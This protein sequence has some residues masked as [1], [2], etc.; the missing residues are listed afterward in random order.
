MKEDVLKYTK[1]HGLPPAE[2][3]TKWKGFDVYEVQWP[4]VKVNGMELVSAI[5]PPQF[6]L[7]KGGKVRVTTYDEGF[8]ILHLL[9]KDLNE[10]EDED[11]ED[12][13]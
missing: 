3:V 13:E 2:L 7:D 1:K 5:G 8:E 6:L 12:L 9:N 4:V 11:D 10:E